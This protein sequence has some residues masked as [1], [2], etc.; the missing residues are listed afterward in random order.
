MGRSG[1]FSALGTYLD[2]ENLIL[3]SVE[4]TEWFIAATWSDL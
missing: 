2:G 4:T 1:P 3:K